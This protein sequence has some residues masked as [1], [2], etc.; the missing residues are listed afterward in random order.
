MNGP[1]GNRTGTYRIDNDDKGAPVVNGSDEDLVNHGLGA[2]RDARFDI[3]ALKTEQPGSWRALSPSSLSFF[4]SFPL[5]TWREIDR[6]MDYGIFL[7]PAES[8]KG[9]HFELSLRGYHISKVV[10][11]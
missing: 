2:V 9:V 4:S 5:F 11:F 6:S 1:P 10:V 8:R 7:S 3:A